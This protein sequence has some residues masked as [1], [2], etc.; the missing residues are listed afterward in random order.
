MN[1]KKDK[2]EHAKFVIDRFDHYN[3][4]VNNKGAFSIA[5]NTFLLGGLCVGFLSLYEKIDKPFYLLFM[6]TIF[7]LCNLASTV[8]TIIA[9]NPF[10]TSGN[11]KSKRSLI[12]FGSV[13]QYKKENYIEAFL[14]QD[15]NRAINDTVSQAWHLA[16]GLTSK[17]RKLKLAG[18]LLIGQFVFLTFIIYSVTKNLL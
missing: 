6:L 2:Y 11:D 14:S 12:F 9:I 4:S 3:D 10:L 18:W 17:Y 13:S 7:G 16:D 15:E 1:D 5:L 8:L